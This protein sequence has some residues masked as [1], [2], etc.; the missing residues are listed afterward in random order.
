MNPDQIQADEAKALLGIA[1][2]MSEQ[3]MPNTM[4]QDEEEMP[5]EEM[6]MESME[7][8][9]PMEMPQAPEE[10][11]PEPEKVD[12]DETTQK[13]DALA[14]NLESFKGEVKG[15]IETSIGDLTKSIKDAI[16]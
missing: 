4:L 12:E 10:I 2:R 1:T 8:E 15:I 11:A 5:M 7:E 3:M 14:K 13:I 9:V 16:E 6:P